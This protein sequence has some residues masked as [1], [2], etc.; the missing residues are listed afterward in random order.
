MVDQAAGDDRL[1]IVQL[2]EDWP[3]NL[4]GAASTVC[5]IHI[6]ETTKAPEHAKASGC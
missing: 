1:D 4:P 2:V 5:L 3:N 6:C